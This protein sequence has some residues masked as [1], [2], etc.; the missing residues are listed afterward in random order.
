V[1]DLDDVAVFYQELFPAGVVVRLTG[2]KFK[3]KSFG[4]LCECARA[5]RAAAETWGSTPT[6]AKRRLLVHTFS[7]SG[8]WTWTAMLE[9]WQTLSCLDEP[10]PLVGASLPAI[11]DV[12]RGVLYDS[13]PNPKANVDVVAG[14]R[15]GEGS[16]FSAVQSLGSFVYHI[17]VADQDHDGSAEGRQKAVLQG[18]KAQMVL[19]AGN[20]PVREYL[21]QNPESVAAMVAKDYALRAA[22]LDSGSVDRLEPPVPL[23]FIYS[24]NDAVISDEGIEEYIKRV[25]KRPS[26]KGLAEPRALVFEKGRHCFHKEDHR[27][28][29]FKC[30]KVFALGASRTA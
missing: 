26:R 20:S 5:I 7:N 28:E 17:A 10:H 2:N 21:R 19:I 8:F 23:Q 27:E 18:K 6:A 9:S 11:A 1:R 24:R 29:Y 30:V 25:I 3:P 4:L 22:H 12:L 14:G 13:S 15:M 16:Y